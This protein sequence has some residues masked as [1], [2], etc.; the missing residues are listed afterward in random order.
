MPKMFLPVL[1]HFENGNPW[2]ASEGRM[3]FLITPEE[4]STFSVQV[5]EGPWA[6]EF[7]T[8]E[9][10]EHFPMTGEGLEQIP[11]WLEERRRE[12]EARPKRTLEENIAR[13]NAAERAGQAKEVEQT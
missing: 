6:L 1:S 5:W 4:D 10:L 7:S 12:I 9:Q 13:R 11:V 2:S 3:R 8:V